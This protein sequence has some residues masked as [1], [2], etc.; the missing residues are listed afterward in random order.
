MDIDVLYVPE[1]PNRMIVR[2]R[3]AEAL[4]QAGL[5]GAIVREHEVRSGQEAERTGMRGSPTILIDGADPFA[6]P[7]QATSLSCR[8][9]SGDAGMGGAPSVEQL[10]EALRP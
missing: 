3:L 10:V 5:S 8:L 7:D 4:E 9:Y 6:A 1:C 2:D